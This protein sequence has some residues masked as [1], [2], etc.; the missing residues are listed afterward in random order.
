MLAQHGW[1]SW[2]DAHLESGGALTLAFVTPVAAQQPDVAELIRRIEA[3]QQR[4]NQLERSPPRPAA[5]APA[6]V[7]PAVRAA[8][9]VAAVVVVPQRR[10]PEVVRAEVDP[11]LRGSLDG[12]AMRVPNTE[13]SVRLLRLHPSDR[14]G[15]LQR[16]QCDGCGLGPGHPADRQRRGPPERWLRRHRAQFAH[17]LRHAHRNQLGAARHHGGGGF[18]R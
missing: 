9:S 15:R 6:P 16:A 11:A 3:L 14:L 7:Q 12:L 8:P 10:T 1:W 4:V 5:R 13:T 17:R 18:P 2:R